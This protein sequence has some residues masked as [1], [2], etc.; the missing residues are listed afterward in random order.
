LGTRGFIKKVPITYQQMEQ[1]GTKETFFS[2]NLSIT[3][4]FSAFSIF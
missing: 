2:Y 4:D 1:D 3:G